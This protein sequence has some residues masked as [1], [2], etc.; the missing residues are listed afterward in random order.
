MPPKGIVAALIAVTLW[1]ANFVAVNAAVTEV[2]PLFVTAWRFS[3]SLAWLKPGVMFSI[4]R[5]RAQMP[6]TGTAK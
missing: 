4:Q 3:V 6:V 2:P 1:G 5:A